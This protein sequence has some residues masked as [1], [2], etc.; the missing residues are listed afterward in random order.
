[1]KKAL[2][3][4]IVLLAA[5]APASAAAAP[6]LT[7][8]GLT[9]T[10]SGYPSTTTQIEFA[11]VHA[12]GTTYYKLPASNGSASWTA[13]ATNYPYQSGVQVDAHD[14]RPAVGS[15]LGREP[16]PFTQSSIAAPTIS[17]ASDGRTL[18]WP[19]LAGAA[20]YKLATSDA[21]AAPRTTTYQGVGNVTSTDPP[22]VSG[23]TR[24][25]A[26]QAVAANGQVSAWSTQVS[27]SYPGTPPP[28]S[29]RVLGTMQ[30]RAGGGP[31]YSGTVSSVGPTVFREEGS[32]DRLIT[33]TNEARAVRSDVLPI[34]EYNL[35]P[36]EVQRLVRTVHP[37]WLEVSNEVYFR[38]GATTYGNGVKAVSQAAKAVD[39]NI[40]VIASAGSPD[41]G[42]PSSWEDGLKP[43]AP[44]FDM[45]AVHPY[46][47]RSHDASWAFNHNAVS[48]TLRQFPDKQVAVTEVGWPTGGPD[49]GYTPV[50]ST[51]QQATFLQHLLPEID[52]TFPGKVP[53]VIL[54]RYNQAGST[55]T[56]EG[57]FSL[58]GKPAESVF[59]SANA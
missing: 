30:N 35:A 51:Q 3:L 11:V 39:P 26:L 6:T 50:V 28:V 17:V 40:K 8:N 55:T 18:K 46:R 4:I 10:A 7:V 44:Y 38:V 37:K 27:V 23:Q 59:R 20:S 52:A 54:Y 12:G 45:L 47:L 36:S 14:Y 58:Q 33:V 24:W 49:N 19:A 2:I 16:M 43:F 21:G 53:I 56:I 32:V 15:W 34:V 22:D 29:D 13:N 25:Y 57:Y 5:A 1:M 9:A 42:V 31:A 48:Y 41:Q